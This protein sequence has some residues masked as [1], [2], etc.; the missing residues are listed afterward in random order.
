[1]D[2][3]PRDTVLE[4]DCIERLRELPDS[5]VDL[6]FADPPYNLQL[7]ADLYRPNMTRVDA[8]DDAWD[9]FSSFAEYDAFTKLPN[10]QQYN[11][12]EC[13]NH[14]TFDVKCSSQKPDSNGTNLNHPVACINWCDAASYCKSRGKRLCGLIGTGGQ[15][16]R[17]ELDME[18]QRQ[19]RTDRESLVRAGVASCQPHRAVLPHCPEGKSLSSTPSAKLH[20]GVLECSNVWFKFHGRNWSTHTVPLRMFQGCCSS[21]LTPPQ[22][23]VPRQFGRSTAMF[24]IRVLGIRR[25]HMSF[26]S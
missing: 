13:A 25:L 8:V 2:V 3:L 20:L 4:G 17:I 23:Y 11:P 6:V 16:V 19:V 22:R 15:L 7:Q 10:L 26:H 18:L 21:C 24:S 1:M 14:V 5:S 12:P 9:K